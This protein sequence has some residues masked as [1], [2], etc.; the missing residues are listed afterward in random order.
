MHLLSF[1]NLVDQ[2]PDLL[3]YP[4]RNPGISGFSGA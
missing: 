4:C 3:T 1:G 2:N